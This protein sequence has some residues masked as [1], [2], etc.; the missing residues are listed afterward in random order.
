MPPTLAT[1]AFSPP[2]P[3]VDQLR[4]LL[5]K[6]LGLWHPGADLGL[7]KSHKISVV[8]LLT[9]FKQIIEDLGGLLVDPARLHKVLIE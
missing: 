1:T 6:G 8:A 2:L 7:L 3:N 4:N 5:D 9:A